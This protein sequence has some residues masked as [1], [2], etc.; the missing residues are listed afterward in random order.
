MPFLDGWR[1]VAILCV[2]LNHFG[3]RHGWRVW[4]GQ[5]GVLMFFALSGHLMGTLLFIKKVELPSFFARRFSRVIPTF[6]LYVCVVAVY[7]ATVQPAPYQVQLSEFVAAM[8]FLRTYITDGVSI[9]AVKWPIG[10]I[11]SLNVEE[12][13]YIYLAAGA[14]LCRRLRLRYAVVAFLFASG[15]AIL[16]MNIYYRAA[17]PVGGS[18]WFLRSECASLGLVAAA[19]F[20]TLRHTSAQA[21]VRSV[22]AL[23]P[24]VSFLVAILCFG[25]YSHK[26]VD[27]TI[28]PICFAFTVTY[29]DCAPALVRRLFGLAVLRWF[30]LLSF[31]L[32]LWQQPFLELTVYHGWRPAFAFAFALGAL[33]FYLFEDP[34]R[35]RLNRAWS[36]RQARRR[37]ADAT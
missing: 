32:Y 35:Q 26:G 36:L 5:F 10:H 28:A 2:L 14:L 9:W 33:S 13:S 17:P 7:A 20:T 37:G 16:G 1:G 6:W 8:T 27:R 23:F 3:D 18:A 25:P 24:V 22:P 34:L 29:L 15:A 31:S 19:A 4:V 11:W 12:H 30:G 21:W